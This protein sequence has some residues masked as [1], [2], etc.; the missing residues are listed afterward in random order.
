[1]TSV[2]YRVVVGTD[3]SDTANLALD[4]AFELAAQHERGEVHV[5][6]AVQYLGEFV[7]MDLPEAAA[8]R[9]PLEEAQEKL[10]ANVGARLSAWQEET[11][12]SISRCV[13]YVSVESPAAAVAQLA[14]DLE[15]ELVVVGTHGRRGLQRFLLGSVAEAVVR[16]CPTP[17]FVVRPKGTDAK[18]PEIEPPCPKCLEARKAS[19]GQELWC[20]EHQQKHGRR[21]VYH[22]QDRRSN[23][24]NM[25]SLL[26][27]HR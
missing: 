2:P 6:N 22:Y 3:F 13:T 1:M 21:H 7:Q 16:L 24:G 17:V 12:K 19:G 9:L 15:A 18:M 8:Y 26:D 25:G 27:T 20:E 14:T 5:L 10:E 4:K 11:K 23:D